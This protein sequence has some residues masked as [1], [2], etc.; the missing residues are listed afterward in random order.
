MQCG[1]RRTVDLTDSAIR[2]INGRNVIASCMLVRGVLET[3]CLLWD[4]IRRVEPIV[5]DGDVTGLEKLN[6]YG[7]LRRICG[8]LPS[9]LRG[10]DALVF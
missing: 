8:S 9:N 2:E 1:V 10:S 4:L 3:S 5:E 7:L 6:K